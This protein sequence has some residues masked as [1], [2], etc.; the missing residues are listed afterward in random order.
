MRD[1]TIIIT[2]NWVEGHALLFE[3]H[4]YIKICLFV[5][6]LSE[7]CSALGPHTRYPKSCCT[8][9]LLKEISSLVNSQLICTHY[10]FKIISTNQHTVHL[11]TLKKPLKMLT[12]HESKGFSRW[13]ERAVI[14][15]HLIEND[16]NAGRP[17]EDNW[18]STVA[19]FASA[20]LPVQ[21]HAVSHRKEAEQPCG[22]SAD[23]NSTCT[24]APSAAFCVATY[25]LTCT[26]LY[27]SSLFFFFTGVL[28]QTFSN[29][30][31]RLSTAVS[32]YISSVAN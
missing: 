4:H 10:L 9:F 26:V 28:N 18:Q 6:Q 19:H 20:H 7:V 8:K 16:I 21:R 23:V 17:T 30:L 29:P 32:L 5:G 2:N 31:L 11:C 12:F 13:R 15:T 25:S 14:I 22:F 24:G 1:V 3:S 27:A